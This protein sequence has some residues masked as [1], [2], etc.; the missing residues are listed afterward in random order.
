MAATDTTRIVI[1][2]ESR[3][4]NLQRTLKGLDTLEKRLRRIANLRVN[5]QQT[6]ATNQATIASQ[7]FAIAQQRLQQTQQRLQLQQQRLAIQ[8]Q[9]VATAQGRAALAAQRLARAQ[10]QFAQGSAVAS[11]AAQSLS[12][13]L[14]A[15]GGAALRVSGGLR[16]LGATASIAVTGPLAALGTLASRSAAD[17]DAVRNRLIATEGS[18]EAANRRLDQLRRLA[19]QSLGVTRRA[20]FD[21]FST[22]SV[23]GDVTEDTINR[24]IQAMGRLN[25]AFTIDDQQ[26]FFRNLIQIFTQGFERADIKEALGRV[27]IFEQLLGQAFG[28]TDRDQLRELKAA[29]KL[30]LD[31]FLLGLAE[32]VNTDPILSSVGESIRVRFQKTFERLTDSLEPLGRAI[33]GPLERIITAIEPIIL[34]LSEA[35]ASL[36]PGV[37]S[38][39]V[40]VGLL[41]AA[42]G[43]VLFV[44][45]GIV[46]GLGALATALAAV[47]PILGTIGLPAL[48][49]ILAGLAVTITRV[50]AAVTALG[51]AWRSNFL[52]IRDLVANAANAVIAAFNRIRVV[53]D[54]AVRRI[55]PTLQSITTKVLG[56]ISRVW[57]NYGQ[58]VVQVVGDAFRFVT[59][60][61]ETFLKLFTDFVDL[62]VKLIDG[63]WRGA[64]RA[65][66]RII[67]TQLDRVGPLFTRFAAAFRKAML[68]LT[69]FLIRQAVVFADAGLRLASS[70]IASLAIGLVA[71]FPKIQNALATV[72]LLAAIGVPLGPIAQALIARLIA[73]LRKAAGDE[74]LLPSIV[75]PPPAGASPATPRRRRAPASVTADDK[76]DDKALRRQLDRLREAQDALAETREEAQIAQLRS[77]IETRFEATK[78]GLDRELT[79]LESNFDD[80]LVAL[81][82]YLDERK[83]LEEAQVD[84]EIAN[85]LEL[86]SVLF[87]E[88]NQRS[89]AAIRAFNTEL[90]EI[91]RDPKLKG[92]AQ[93]AAVET[94]ELKKINELEK[95]QSEFKIKHAE[96]TAQVV[97]LEKDRRAIGEELLRLERQLTEEIQKQQ[98]QLQFDLFEEQG[99]AVD[100]EIGR[101]VAQFRDSL[102][103]LR[104]DTSGL[105][106]DL[107]Q[108]IANVDLSVLQ[109]QLDQL[110]QPVR[111][112]VE[113]LGIGIQRALIA[114]NALEADRALAQ[115]RLE[116]VAIQNKVLDG[117]ISEKQSREEILALQL[118]YKAILLDILA[119]ELARAKVI[120][121]RDEILRIEEQIQEIGRLG[122]AFDE[123]G[124]EIN[125]AF[126]GT[127]EDGFAGF[128]DN[129]RRGFDGLRDAAIS[130][131]E[132]LLG[133]LNRLAAQSITEKLFGDIFKPD[134]TDTKGT[135]GGI[136]G[137]VFGLSPKVPEGAA[138]TTAATTAGTALTTGGT[139]AAAALTTGAATASTTLA[140]SVVTSA[141]SF[142]SAV[143]AAGAAFAAAV[144]AA[145]GASAASG[146]LG[147][148]LG[149]AAESG[150]IFSAVP[151]GAVHVLEGGYPEAW[152][153]T[154]PRHAARQ[155][156][157]LRELIQRTRGFYGRVQMPDLAI[158]GIVSR[159]T[160]E[161]NL[162]SSISRAPSL[163]PHLPDAALET[164]TAQQLMNLR[165]INQV[166]PQQIGHAYMSSEQGVRD[167]MN[168]I[169]TNSNEV[170]RRIR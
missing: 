140:T 163:L 49:V 58:T 53:F 141:T 67:I 119:A 127:I 105:G 26:Q 114:E 115:L 167:V 63:D 76:D 131:G 14:N 42:L 13:Q 9:Q 149:G 154:D 92:E 69:A 102:R 56:V 138:L 90:A 128:F 166:L 21:A 65:F 33:L 17:I 96:A 143:I 101:L 147:S 40:V 168:I 133:I 15:L 88:L 59:D 134:A 12:R 121:D 39:I 54:N 111:I 99:R 32:A 137:R 66:A 159:E 4:R 148:L 79:A 10:Q 135:P 144:T 7:R 110:P 94:A 24:Q 164:A 95:A 100:A 160:A 120:G 158:G 64:W 83:S 85:Q 125:Q 84:A 68:S 103:E 27:P 136:L 106:T 38:A 129:A 44:I 2:L 117:A 72:L 118:R 1:D 132:S 73:E 113:L 130:F 82:K 116:S 11:R 81:R 109:Q 75:V 51:L 50:I 157:I 34:R 25:A 31:T 43:P 20:A 71:G 156:S 97:Q 37:Q 57:E 89:R 162:L 155:V 98:A 107:Q 139:S 86:T 29:G 52:G 60:V 46:S 47:I 3:L 124:Q 153:T 112:L 169:S 18:L 87:Q 5:T 35:F 142:A 6:Q 19:D 91:Q 80:R 152:I 22:L 74:D 108:A 150:G 23:V 41:A 161:A 36:S 123:I 70:F 93:Q 62:V 16:S 122:T 45:G 77:H 48:I 126:F 55:L 28:T 104:V 61:T 146:G 165:I 170:R 78:A 30:T 145:A 8:T 151:G